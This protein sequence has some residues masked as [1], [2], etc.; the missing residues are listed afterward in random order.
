MPFAAELNVRPTH[1]SIYILLPDFNMHEWRTTPFQTSIDF[2]WQ[3]MACRLLSPLCPFHYC[4]CPFSLYISAPVIQQYPRA[5]KTQ[6]VA[7][8]LQLYNKFRGSRGV[9]SSLIFISR[10]GTELEAAPF[11]AYMHVVRPNVYSCFTGN[12]VSA[13]THGCYSN[14]STKHTVRCL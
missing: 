12:C 1:G 6:S 3:K 5:K 11:C 9:S 4:Y 8:L 2:E 10:R 14:R 13:P 7:G